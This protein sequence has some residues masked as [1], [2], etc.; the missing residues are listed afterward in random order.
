M[1]AIPLADLLLS[2]IQVTIKFRCRSRAG[3]SRGHNLE[4]DFWGVHKCLFH[5]KS[6]LTLLFDIRNIVICGGHYRSLNLTLIR[7]ANYCIVL[8]EV[9]FDQMA[10]Q[11]ISVGKNILHKTSFD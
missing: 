11:L 3:L 10:R 1:K 9:N 2:S 5:V 4:L 7:L 6:F 8:F